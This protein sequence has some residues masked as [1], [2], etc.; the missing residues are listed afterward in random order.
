MLNI[1]GYI[2]EKL[3]SQR[4]KYVENKNSRAV[5]NKGGT[6]GGRTI[7]SYPSNITIGKNSYINGGYIQASPNAKIIIGDN[8]LISYDVHI[9][10]GNHNYADKNTLIREQGGNEKD[11]IIG[12]DV[13]I[14]FGAQVMP[15][16]HI[17]DGCVIAAGAVVTKDTEPYCVYGGVPAKKIKERNSK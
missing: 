14:G 9:R 12:N 1:L 4:L 7:L 8:C 16:V 10:T 5:N 11:V 2:L 15:G 13:W 17:A 3:D 6:V